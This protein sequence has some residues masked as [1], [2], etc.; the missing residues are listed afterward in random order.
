MNGIQKAIKL[1][2]SQVALANIIGPKV[3]QGHISYW[4]KNGVPA[5][6]AIEIETALNGQV[7]REELCPEIFEAPRPT[8]RVA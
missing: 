1:A 4:I 3:K 8:K 2:G 6:R 7:T 5:N